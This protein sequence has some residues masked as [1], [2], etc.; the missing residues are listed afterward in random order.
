[1]KIIKYLAKSFR[2]DLR[3]LLTVDVLVFNEKYAI[4]KKKINE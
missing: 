2:Y 3:T 1:M 4:K